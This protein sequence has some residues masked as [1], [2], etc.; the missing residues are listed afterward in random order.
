MA[1]M[2]RGHT[3]GPSM[4]P[5]ASSS[6][7]RLAASSFASPPKALHEDDRRGPYFAFGDHAAT[8]SSSSGPL[9]R[10]AL[11]AFDTGQTRSQSAGHGRSSVPTLPSRSPSHRGQPHSPRITGIRSCSSIIAAFGAQVTTAQVSTHSPAAR[12][13]APARR[14]DSASG[15]G[16]T[17]RGWLV[18]ALSQ[19]GAG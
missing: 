3:R 10:T 14:R 18:A 5:S 16:R 8:G 6:S 12:W 13:P 2:I 17:S 1:R 9:L 19:F 4:S 15:R 7:A 11:T